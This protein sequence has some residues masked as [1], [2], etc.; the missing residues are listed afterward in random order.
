MSGITSKQNRRQ[1]HH[2]IYCS[3]NRLLLLIIA[4]PQ[5]FKQA[6]AR[7]QTNNNRLPLQAGHQSDRSQHPECAEKI[8]DINQPR[9]LTQ[10]ASKT[11]PV[12]PPL[13]RRF[14]IFSYSRAVPARRTLPPAAVREEEL[15]D[16]AVRPRS[17]EVGRHYL[18]RLFAFGV[19]SVQQ[20]AKYV[21][22]TNELE[23]DGLS[24]H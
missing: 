24:V 13:A 2:S 8:G 1:I 10:P 11:R 20:R 22:K 6:R 12:F 14:N 17:A 3:K 19:K 5:T 4:S 9:E 23:F 21:K 15:R 16:V 18:S 7:L